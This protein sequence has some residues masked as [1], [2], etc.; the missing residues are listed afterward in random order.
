MDSIQYHLTVR[1]RMKEGDIIDSYRRLPVGRYRDI[2]DVCRDESLDDLDRQVKIIAILAD[3]AEDDVLNM[4]LEKYAEMAAKTRF[5]ESME[6]TDANNI[7]KAYY[8]GGFKL[9]PVTDHRRITAAQ[10][11]D[12]QE[13]AKAGDENLVEILSCLLI[14]EGMTYNRGYDVV[15][16]QNAIRQDMSVADALAL[17]AFFFASYRRSI[18]ASLTSSRKAAA[19]IR[20]RRERRAMLER[21]AEQEELLRTGGAGSPTLTQF[22]RPAAANGT[23]CGRCL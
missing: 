8:V 6:T 21:I 13:Y 11:I 2:R 17:T 19:K 9:V 7:S 12:F 15:D 4:P 20:D 22:P 14:P 18:S 23:R 10:Y 5:L 1:D 3:M 16:V